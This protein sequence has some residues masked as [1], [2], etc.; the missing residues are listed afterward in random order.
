LLNRLAA[1]IRTRRE[2]GEIGSGDC[3]I[4]ETGSDAVLG[5]RYDDH[6]SAIVTLNNLS[7]ERQ[8]I[9]LDL[10]EL[11]MDTATNLVSDKPYGPVASRNGRMR[12]Y[13]HGFRWLRIGGAY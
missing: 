8:T 7:P 5:L 13:G 4:L 6:Q 11:E 10:T 12:I 2:C 1:L 9:T 3:R